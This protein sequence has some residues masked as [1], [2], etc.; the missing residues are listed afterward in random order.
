MNLKDHN[1]NIL[2]ALKQHL[3][4][5]ENILKLTLEIDIDNIPVVKCEYYPMNVNSEADNQQRKAS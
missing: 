3:E 5:P 1:L 4:I 2:N